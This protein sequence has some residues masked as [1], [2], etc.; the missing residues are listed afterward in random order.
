MSKVAGYLGAVYQSTGNGTNVPDETVALAITTGIGDT[1]NANVIVNALYE[2]DGGAK[3]TIIAPGDYTWTVKG[4][5]TCVSQANANVHVDYTYYTVSEVIGFSNWSLDQKAEAFNVTDFN[6]GQAKQFIAGLS[7]FSA[8]ADRY[9]IS[10]SANLLGDVNEK[11]IIKFYIDDVSATKRSFEGWC[12]I[13]GIS[14]D[15]AVDSVITANL[16]F[17]GTN[18]LSYEAI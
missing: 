15:V 11:F 7:E 1:V 3:S 6:D 9:W 17:Q 12:Y 8:T 2:D 14:P 4:E 18:Q 16:T 13:T 10:A 5:I